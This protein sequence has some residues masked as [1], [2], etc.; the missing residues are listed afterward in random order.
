MNS[1]HDMGGRHGMGP[2]EHEKDEP[3]FHAPWEGRVYAIN[4]AMRAHGKWDLDVDR[5]ALEQLPPADYLRWS[6]YEKWLRRLELQVVQY[7]MATEQELQSG[8]SVASAP[9][10]KPAMTMAQADRWTVRT[11]P[12]PI[13]PSIRP[14]FKV[15]EKVRAKNMH[16]VTHTRLPMYARGKQGV[17]VRDHGV[18][19]FNDAMAHRLGEQ[20]QHVYAVRFTGR[21]LWGPQASAKHHIHIDLWDDHLEHP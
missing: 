17:I 14:R 1:V 4:R 18:Y 11:L 3:V 10:A 5:Y 8:H 2:I 13:Q 21:E 20:R 12:S 7:G 6:Y 15:G 16:P 9:V 19:S